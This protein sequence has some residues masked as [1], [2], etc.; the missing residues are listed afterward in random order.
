MKFTEDQ[1]TPWF[2]GTVKPK[3]RGVY[4]VVVFADQ[5]AGWK[6]SYFNGKRWGGVEYTPG[7]AAEKHIR[8]YEWLN[9]PGE[10]KRWRG[11]NFNPEAQ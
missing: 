2:D 8:E 5:D 10:L 1:M 9:V 3:R 11:L 6:F 4:E 7:F